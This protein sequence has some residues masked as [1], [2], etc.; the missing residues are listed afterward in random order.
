MSLRARQAHME[1]LIQG[2]EVSRLQNTETPS[3]P[4]LIDQPCVRSF[5]E[6]VVTSALLSV[7][8][9]MH[10]RAW[11]GVALSRGSSCDYLS[12]LLLQ[13][14]VQSTS[15]VDSLTVDMG[16]LL[17]RMLEIIATPD[18]IEASSQEG[19]NLMNFDKRK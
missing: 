14:Y 12:S 8:S 15:S 11:Q 13:P 4:Q 17:E 7:E 2:I 6:A 19:Q 3:T 18:I 10:H 16:W 1:L 9:L 5:V